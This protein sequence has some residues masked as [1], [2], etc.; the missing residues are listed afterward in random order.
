[1]SSTSRL[2]P[3]ARVSPA[4]REALASPGHRIGRR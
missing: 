4:E 1:V 2:C 3:V